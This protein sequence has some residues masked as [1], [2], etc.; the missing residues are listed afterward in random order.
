MQITPY[1]GK[2]DPGVAKAIGWDNSQ[3]VEYNIQHSK[4]RDA[5]AN[6]TAGAQT[7]LAKAQV[8]LHQTEPDTYRILVRGSFADYLV[9]WLLDA[10]T[11]YVSETTGADP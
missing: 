10:M 4:W 11:E 9:R 2:L 8:V 1:K 5:K 3:G 6:L 7:M